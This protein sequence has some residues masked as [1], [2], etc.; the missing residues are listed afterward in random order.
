M[1]E[2][3]VVIPT[4]RRPEM[5]ERCLKALNEQRLGPQRFEVIVAD[6]AGDPETHY[7][8][9]QLKLVAAFTLSYVP[10]IGEHGPAAARNA[11][12]RAARGRIVAFTDDDCLP[13]PGWLINGLAA[14]TPG[15]IGVAGKIRMPL[16]PRPT[17]YE[18][19][20]AGLEGAEFVT[21]NCFYLKQ[22]LEKAGGFDERFRLAWREDSDLYFTLLQ[23][24]GQFA[25]AESAVVVHPVRPGRWGV[26]LLQTK[27]NLYDALLYKKHPSLYRSKIMPGPPRLYYLITA[28]LLTAA[29]L[30][31]ARNYAGASASAAVWA[32]ATLFFLS[33]RVRG[34]SRAPSHL[35]EMA[36]TSVPVPLAAVFWRLAGAVRYKVLF[37]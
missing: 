10:V 18:L 8:V 5:L 36:V 22:A 30:L 4:Y 1:I 37:V 28:S 21:A 13:Q 27:K 2:I 34:T 9:S 35:L 24:G 19:N 26:S 33:R 25:R 11:G 23:S 31:A 15:I 7:L 20:A 6:D 32:A 29:A 17:D 14:F 12:W 3:S 16:P